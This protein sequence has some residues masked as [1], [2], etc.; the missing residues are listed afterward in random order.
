MGIKKNFVLL[1]SVAIIIL[2]GILA[3]P[4]ASAATASVSVSKTTLSLTRDL[5]LGSTGEEVRS[6]QKFLNN[7]GYF[8]STSGPGSIGNETTTFD[9]TTKTALAAFQAA[10]NLSESGYVGALTRSFVAKWK[11]AAITPAT[12]SR[13]AILAMIQTVAAKIA[14]LQKQL[15]AIIAESKE[16]ASGPRITAIKT[17]NGGK[18]ENIDKNDS[19]VITFSEAI[20]PASINSSLTAGGS[21]TDVLSSM[22]GGVSITSYG[23]LTI[24]NI[25]SF[26]VGTVG[27]SR[28]FTSKI[29]LDSTS[30]ILTV[31]LTSADYVEIE[32]ESFG[33]VAQIGGKVTGTTGVMADS[34][35]TLIPTGTFG[36]GTAAVDTD[37]T[38]NPYI[39]QIMV[40]DDGDRG[41][42]D[43]GDVIRIYFNEDIKP[44]SINKFLI[45]GGTVNDIVPTETGGVTVANTGMITIKNI[46]TFDM[47]TAA[48]GSFVVNLALNS[49][50]R[51]LTITLAKGNDLAITEEE[52]SIGKE[53]SSAIK[54]LDGQSMISGAKIEEV[55]GTFGDVR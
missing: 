21:V 16:S 43:T 45:K 3:A 1:G 8:V 42:I 19:I 31:T 12:E 40:I 51:I 4:L 9:T 22:V 15:A 34:A 47:G 18:K 14:E 52:L 28:N 20:K 26:A 11:G 55:T 53:V 5:S 44:D 54:D 38:D 7:N 33:T 13:A 48:A 2:M 50:G 49:T 17:S 6:L 41:V 23:Q 29:G 35:T 10:N 39:K 37:K 30:K 25:A 24:K 36:G 27:D 32:N 46:A